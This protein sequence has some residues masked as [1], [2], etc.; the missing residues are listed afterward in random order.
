VTAGDDLPVRRLLDVG[1]AL[2]SDLDVRTILDRVLAAARE[3]TGARYAALGVLNESRTELAE[4]LTTGIDAA[5]RRAI[6]EAPHG[7]GVLGVLI[8]DP[9]PLR[10]GD[11]S[12]HPRS[13]GFPEGHPQMHSFLGAPLMIRGESWGNLYLADKRGAAEFTESDEEAVVILAEW[14][15]VAIENAR[16]YE[17]SEERRQ[18]LERAVRG[19]EATRDVAVA[20]GGSTGPE[21]VLELIAKRGRALIDA[22]AVLI[23]LREGDELVVVASAG[24]AEDVSG[25]RLP[26]AGSTSGQ[27][28]E[29]GRSERIPQVG[30]R[31]RI[32]PAELGVPDA[33]TALLVPMS[34]RGAGIG[35]LAAFDR[36]E[37]AD[38]FTEADEHL[39]QTF[40]A[41]GANAVAIARSVEADRLRSSLA[42]ADAERRHWARELHDDTLQLLGGLRVLLSGSLRRGDASRFEA[43]MREAMHEVEQGIAG[44]RTIIADLRPAALDEIG[45]KPAIDALLDRRREAGL[46]IVATLELPEPG[47]EQSRLAPELETTVY[48]FVQEGLTNVIKHARASVVDVRVRASDDEVTIEIRDDGTGFDVGASTT[49]FGLA[50]M[51][52][53]VFLSQGSLEIESGPQGT[54]LR[55]V[56]PTQGSPTTRGVTRGLV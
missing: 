50:G 12:A 3:I 34:H 5:T 18:Q 38:A 32:A 26:I 29:R 17:R 44:L 40:A 39:L 10:L 27:V 54:V 4:F 43:V 55:A 36:G 1:R 53:R 56:L 48:R 24:Y 28:L 21:R 35:V 30:S 37:G 19:L 41:S 11:V 2:V 33:H 16:L 6:G 47:A 8:D 15:S 46:E 14:A 42:A 13:Y 25:H 22:R 49:G 45:L 20:I 23:M 52:E 31:L 9:R 7:R 51:R